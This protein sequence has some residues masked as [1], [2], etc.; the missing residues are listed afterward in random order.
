[1]RS[2]LRVGLGLSAITLVISVLAG[3]SALGAGPPPP[4]F[5]VSVTNTPL[6]VTVTNATTNQSVTITNPASNPVKTSIDQYPRTPIAINGFSPLSGYT[7][8]SDQRLVIE[9]ISLSISGC[10]QGSA[11]SETIK[12]GS[13]FVTVVATVGSFFVGSSI[14]NVRIVVDHDQ[15]VQDNSGTG[16]GS[17]ADS[18]N[19][20][21]NGYLVSVNSPS[22]AP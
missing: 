9:T 2:N 20:W 18:P 19:L 14:Q 3:S 10:S 17:C 21:L 5:T 8:P 12:A 22:L 4:G 13:A 7:V 16:T 1:M 15:T 11:R 6:P